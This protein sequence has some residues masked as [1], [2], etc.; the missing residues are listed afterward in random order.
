[1]VV[2]G[3]LRE[4]RPV[5][6]HEQLAGCRLS[7]PLRAGDAD[8]GRATRSHRARFA[9]DIIDEI[10]ERAPAHSASTRG[11]L[12]ST[13]S[14]VTR[15]SS[16]RA[17]KREA[18]APTR[19]STKSSGA[20]APAV[21]PTAATPSNQLQSTSAADPTRRASLAPARLATSTKRTEFDDF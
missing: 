5:C 20:L 3:K 7:R 2:D 10:G 9:N 17:S 13:T 19:S 8:Q 14:A 18:I 12:N 1:D 21:T 6:G 15:T 16:S 11:S 4:A